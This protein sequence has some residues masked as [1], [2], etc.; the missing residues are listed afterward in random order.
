MRPPATTLPAKDLAHGSPRTARSFDVT[1]SAWLNTD[2]HFAAGTELFRSPRE[3]ALWAYTVSHGQLLLRSTAGSPDG[4]TRIDVLFKP[5]QAARIRG[6]YQGLV[7]RIANVTEIDRI[8][9]DCSGV[10]W[11]PQARFLVVETAGGA[12]FVVCGAVGWHEDAGDARDPSTLAYFPPG[13]DPA[14]ILPG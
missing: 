2:A 1:E 9:T 3:F 12:D 4:D 11:T 7:I 5:I 10:N 13:T 6:F 8:R 14:R